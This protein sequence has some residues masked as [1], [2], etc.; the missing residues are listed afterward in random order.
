MPS[1]LQR[2][3]LERADTAGNEDGLGEEPRALVR[4]DEETAVV[5]LLHLGHLL[6]EVEGG[7]ERLDLA[8]QVV[9]ELLAGAHGHGRDV[10]DRLVGIEL[11]TLTAG[12]AQRV[13]DVAP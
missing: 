6:A 13:D 11:D 3:R 9:R 7:T 12:V 1:D 2:A 4:L 8:Q 10:V 5:L